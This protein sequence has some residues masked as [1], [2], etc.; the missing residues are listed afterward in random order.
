MYALDMLMFSRADFADPALTTFL[1]AHL[2]D[3]EPTAPPD[4]RH[5]LDLR[6]LQAP[7][8]R[9]WVGHSHSRLVATG[10]LAIVGERHEEVK[11]MRT[12]PTYRGTGIGSAM[13]RQLLQ[14]AR[15]RDVERVSLETGS[16]G[17]FAAA[18]ALYAKHGFTPCAPFGG[19]V[20]DPNSVY[21]SL[22]LEA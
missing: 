14:D 13:V 21:L 1:Q 10:A 15:S 12:D 22:K 11:S 2:D 18:R 19:Y 3:V 9:L 5:A 8:M 4:S 20:D 6:A 16:M 7:G 17:F